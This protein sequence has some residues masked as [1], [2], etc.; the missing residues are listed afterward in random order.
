MTENLR[1]SILTFSHPSIVILSFIP[2][3]KDWTIV[4]ESKKISWEI[5]KMS[6]CLIWSGQEWEKGRKKQFFW[7]ILEDLQF[8]TLQK[9]RQ[10]ELD[11]NMMKRSSNICRIANMSYR[12]AELVS[13]ASLSFL[14]KFNE[15]TVLE[16]STRWSCTWWLENGLA[17]GGL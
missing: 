10:V 4:T 7:N 15:W 8:W 13:K 11:M 6:L 12:S 1:H 16:Y 9:D 14:S 5:R 17:K 3:F 2:K